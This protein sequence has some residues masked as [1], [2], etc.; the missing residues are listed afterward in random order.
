MASFL[1][2]LAS[3]VYHELDYR[4]TGNYRPHYFDLADLPRL[5]K[6]MAAGGAA[7]LTAPPRPHLEFGEWP[8][9]VYE[10]SPALRD[11][12]PLALTPAGRAEFLR[13]VFHGGIEFRVSLAEL[14]SLLA[15][16]D[17]RPDRGLELTY[18]LTPSWQE[19]VPDALTPAGWERLKGYLVGR[20]GL[21]GKWIADAKLVEPSVPLKPGERGVNVFAHFDYASG[22]Q[23]AANG[24]VEVL[25]RAGVRTS[26]RDLPITF[27]PDPKAPRKLGLEEYDTSVF[28]V[29]LNTFPDEW[30]AAAG[31][32]M[33]PNTKRIAVWYWEME[34]IPDEWVRRLGWADEVWAPTRFTADTFRKYV[35]APVVPMLPGV[36][37]PPFAPLPRSEFG[38]RD[39]R[40]TFLFTFDMASTTIRKNPVGLV[41]AFRKAFRRDEP[42]ELVVKVT[43]GEIAP[44][45]F[46]QLEAECREAGVTLLHGVYPRERLFALMNACDC[47]A[48]LHRS[49]GLGLGML[50]SML[51]GKPV[52]GS[53]YS[54]NL[55]FM[56]DENSYLVNSTRAPCDRDTIPYRRGFLWGEPDLDHAAAQ[57]RRVYDHQAE[58]RAKGELARRQVGQRMSM[59]A[60]QRRVAERLETLAG[61]G[62]KKP[63]PG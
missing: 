32:R 10:L 2:R 24:L 45:D 29:G 23:Q 9:R 51:M 38:L 57:L 59:A 20:Y 58:A 7:P 47:Y 31:V 49:E 60:Y 28:V 18:R 56:T 22:L 63:H 33:R 62:G 41:R 8:L 61:A 27:R 21:R 26:L 50:E 12:I 34:D 36:E 16:I 44:D 3:R 15:A 14:L 17:E 55:D 54:G 46:A 40:F 6:V 25:H 35:T 39:D 11:Q 42:V 30:L 5:N 48:S 1:H 19:A 13:W 37:L 53:G 52:V 4:L 43:R